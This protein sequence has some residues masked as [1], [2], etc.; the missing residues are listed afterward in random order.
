MLRGP[1]ER[2]FTVDIFKELAKSRKVTKFG[3]FAYGPTRSSLQLWESIL[4][5]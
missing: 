2:K 5:N 4:S 1:P 3:N